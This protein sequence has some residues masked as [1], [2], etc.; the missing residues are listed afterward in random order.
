MLWDRSTLQ[1][2]ANTVLLVAG[3]LVA[4]ILVGVPPAWLVARTDL[5]GRRVLAVAA[6]LPL[7]IP[8]YVLRSACSA[9]S[10]RAGC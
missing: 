7:V 8:S 6:P 1:L 3:D 5:P 9:P 2:V 10:A 4:A